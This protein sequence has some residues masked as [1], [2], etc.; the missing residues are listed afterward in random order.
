MTTAAEDKIYKR[1][2][3][4]SYAVDVACLAVFGVA[5]SVIEFIPPRKI[6]Y[7]PNDPTISLEQVTSVWVPN[8]MLPVSVSCF[9]ALFLLLTL[10]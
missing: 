4:T 2:I 10:F 6:V 9:N 1:K 5:A 3:F 8:W 7:D